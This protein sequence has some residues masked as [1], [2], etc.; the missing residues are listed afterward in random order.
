[1]RQSSRINYF[2]EAIKPPQKPRSFEE[3]KA[4]VW[5]VLINKFPSGASR[6]MI[7]VECEEAG[8][9]IPERVLYSVLNLFIK[10]GK[11]AYRTLSVVKGRSRIFAPVISK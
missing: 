3:T 4:I 7:E 5:N 1:M 11:L 10:E 6:R 8:Q 9:R 2:A